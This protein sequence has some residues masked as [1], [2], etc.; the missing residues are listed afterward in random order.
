MPVHTIGHSTLAP[1]DFIALLRENGV[2]L[3]VDIRAIPRSRRNPDYNIETL[4][5]L[6][7]PAGIGHTHIAELGGRRGKSKA[8]TRNGFWENDAFRNYADYALTLPFR[9]GL[10]RL[11][12]LAADH[13]PAIMCAE[14]LWWQCHRRIVTDHLL[15]SGCPVIHIMGPGKAEGAVLNKGA[16]VADGQLLYPAAQASLF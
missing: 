2:D 1:E 9:E 7:R 13:R 3:L 6:L 10:D 11:L 12:G 4:P 14:A 15:A 5:G 16:V 8:P